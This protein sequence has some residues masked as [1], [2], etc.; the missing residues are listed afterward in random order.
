MKQQFNVEVWE[1]NQWVEIFRA[2]FNDELDAKI[3]L[4]NCLRHDPTGKYQIV[5]TW[6]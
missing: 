6:A 2:P 5:E 3:A 1:K 4:R